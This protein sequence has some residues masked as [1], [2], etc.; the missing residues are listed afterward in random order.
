MKLTVN[1]PYN[2]Y[3]IPIIERG[4]LSQV[5]SWVKGLGTLKI[6]IITD[7]LVGRLYSQTVQASLEQAGFD[8]IAFEFPEGEAS[9]ILK[10]FI[11]PTNFFKNGM[12]RSDGILALGGGWLEISWL[13]CFNL[14]A[15]IH[16]LQ[17]P[18]SL[19]AQV[20]SSIGGKLA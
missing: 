16:F 15:G 2:P 11:K 3:D 18:M 13:R 19:T 7:D 12:T 10:L 8:T 17:V 4:S 5:G 1:L 9:K 20:D 6:V 14:Y